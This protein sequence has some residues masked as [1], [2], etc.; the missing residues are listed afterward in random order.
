MSLNKT[1][2]DVFNLNYLNINLIIVYAYDQL[3]QSNNSLYED[4]TPRDFTMEFTKL[5]FSAS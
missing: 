5:S 2:Q 4:H 1:Y 3:C